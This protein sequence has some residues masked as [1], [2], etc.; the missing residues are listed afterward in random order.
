MTIMRSVA[1]LIAACA[2]HIVSRSRHLPGMKTSMVKASEGDG[3][4]KALVRMKESAIAPT[5]AIAA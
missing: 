3:H 2:I 1:M 5:I 4:W